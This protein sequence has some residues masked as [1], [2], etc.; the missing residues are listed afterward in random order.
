[1]RFLGYLLPLGLLAGCNIG[2]DTD[3]TLLLSF[4]L[5]VKVQSSDGTPICDAVVTASEGSY[6]ETLNSFGDCSYAGAGE[7]AGTYTVRASKSG[8]QIAEQT[9]I[10]VE[11]DECHVIG[12]S[13]TLT[14]TSTGT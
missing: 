5:N 9:G 14:L 1:M 3:C 10:E 4:G 13:V 11:E 7:R 8:F 2:G 12:E 6:Q